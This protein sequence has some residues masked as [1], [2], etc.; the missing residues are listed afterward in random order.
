[1]KVTH[2][3]QPCGSSCG[4]TSLKMVLNELGIYE[5]KTPH[6]IF[7]LGP[8]RV[9]GVP[10]HR[11]VYIMKY[12]NLNFKVVK[13]QTLIE[14]ADYVKDGKYVLLSVML[15]GIKHWVVLNEVEGDVYTKATYHIADPAVGELKLSYDECYSYA[16]PRG[17]VAIIIDPEDYEKDWEE[18]DAEEV[19]LKGGK[20]NTSTPGWWVDEQKI[21]LKIDMNWFWDKKCLQLENPV[22]VMWIL[23]GGTEQEQFNQLPYVK[24]NN[25]EYVWAVIPNKEIPT[26]THPR[27]HN[28]PNGILAQT[29]D[30]SLVIWSLTGEKFWENNKYLDLIEQ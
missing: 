12:M 14:L 21:R 20:F 8:T 30:E 28:Y 1:M 3:Y 19:E 24:E 13:D 17:M 18:E 5:D 25:I 10:L 22:N 23:A 6:D 26:L 15:S 2:I 29:E 7:D 4:P 11:L 9:G 16:Y 27:F